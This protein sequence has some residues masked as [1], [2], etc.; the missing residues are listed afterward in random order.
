MAV[1][2]CKINELTDAGWSCN[3]SIINN[4]G[5]GV[6]APLWMFS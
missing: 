2:M 4:L 6:D 5:G 3:Q 1:K